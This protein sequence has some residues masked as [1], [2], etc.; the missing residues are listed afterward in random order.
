[1]NKTNPS[2]NHAELPLW[3]EKN[4]DQK[5]DTL[6]NLVLDLYRYSLASPMKKIEKM[7]EDYQPY[8]DKEKKDIEQIKKYIFENPNLLNKNC[9]SG[10]FTG[11]ALV[12]D[13]ENKKFLLHLHK[14]LDKWL[15]FGG[16]ADYE[17]DLSEVAM[18]EAAEETGLK[19]LRFI[20]GRN[21]PIPTDI[22]IHI[23]PERKGQPEHPHLDFRYILVTNTP[24]SLETDS[25]DES[26][27]YKWF[28]FEN[29]EK[30][31]KLVNDPALYRLISKAKLIVNN[32]SS[33]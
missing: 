7:L 4:T 8:D 10:H 18:R 20:D 27:E 24:D 2:P 28:S 5:L 22:D 12:V 3:E 25:E 32:L 31:S 11:S 19:D 33:K 21:E 6:R 23:I 29:M 9:E 17:T 15:Q 30:V 13:L 16:H 1:M 26:N 14:K